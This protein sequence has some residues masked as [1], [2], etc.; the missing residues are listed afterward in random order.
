MG[1]AKYL[2]TYWT[3]KGVSVNALCPGGSGGY[4]NQLR[5]FVQKFTNLIPMGRM[6]NINEYKAAGL[7]LVFDASSYMTGAYLIVDG[8]G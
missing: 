3:A 7:F 5:D 1:F 4:N 2:A 6:V 8:G